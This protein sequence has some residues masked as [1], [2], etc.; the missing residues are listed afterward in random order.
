MRSEQAWAYPW[1][2]AEAEVVLA[3][4]DV[5]KRNPNPAFDLYLY[6]RVSGTGKVAQNVIDLC[7]DKWETFKEYLKGY[8]FAG[9][10]ARPGVA[11]FFLEPLAEGLVDEAWARSPSEGFALHNLAV[12]M[13]MAAAGECVPEI[14]AGACAP[15]PTLDRDLK[16]SLERLGLV[17]NDA[18][19]LSVKY[20][21]MTYQP[22][23]GGC[24]VCQMGTSCP[25]SDVLRDA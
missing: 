17:L 12:T 24:A 11:L 20:A 6:L 19:G 9:A 25:K 23:V 7:Q 3:K 21:V 2:Q 14:E 10:K 18:G 22:Y 15:L 1:A 16:R 5:E 13:V 4:I 8:H